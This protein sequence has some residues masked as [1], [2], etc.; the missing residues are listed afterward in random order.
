MV[1]V[2]QPRDEAEL[3]DFVRGAN[4][5][6]HTLEVCGF[7]SKRAA[8]RPLTA[9]SVI[10]TAK[11]TGVT[12]YEPN[13]LVISARAGTP[14]HELE[15]T[16]ARHNQELTFEPSDY[17][18]IY[19]NEPL[20][21]S[22]GAVAA[23]NI[24]GPRRILRGA[25]RDHLLGIRAVNGV[26]DIIKNGGH[27][28]KNVTGV[29]LVRG[30]AG[31][32]GTLAV[33]TEVTFKVLPLARE[34]RTLLFFGLSDEAAVGAMSAA[35]GTPYEVSGTIHLQPV[36]AGRITDKTIAPANTAVTALRLEGEPKFIGERVQRL[37][38]ELSPFGEIYELAN[39]QSRGFWFDIRSLSFLSANFDKPL[40]RVSVSPSRAPLVV[41]A[42][43][44]FFEITAAFDW[45]GGLIWIETPVSSD[46]NATE[47]RR[48]LAEFSSDACIMR[49]SREVRASVEVFQP[50]PL[51]KMKLVQS[52][53]KAFDPSAVLNPG[54]MYAGV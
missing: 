44:R 4:A 19:G 6:R 10:S 41:G 45:S 51:A 15:A 18:R 25:A 50:L 29:D 1:D 40:W 53:K 52:V 16:L 23:A 32:W 5:G 39:E 2:I 9:T 11:L 54:R 28:M 36:M 42:L 34:S 14:L 43:G 46:A 35:M 3:A 24:S 12:H 27:V 26:G 8:G 13:E 30:L 22:I 38:K 20:A 47:M 49:A 21:A 7:R 31:S 37:R 33:L 17:S 48:V